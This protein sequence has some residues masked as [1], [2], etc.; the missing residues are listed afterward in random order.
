MKHRS[1][2]TNPQI[3]NNNRFFVQVTKVHQIIQVLSKKSEDVVNSDRRPQEVASM[4]AE[5]NTV[6]L[7]CIFTI[8][9]LKFVSCIKYILPILTELCSSCH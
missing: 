6:I 3:Q 2:R 7:V 1:I 4:I 5:A 9:L 8:V